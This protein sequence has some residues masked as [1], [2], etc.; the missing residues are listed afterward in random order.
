[1]G[2]RP[3]D[4]KGGKVGTW[5]GEVSTAGGG[6]MQDFSLFCGTSGDWKCTVKRLRRS[7]T[8]SGKA[9]AVMNGLLASVSCSS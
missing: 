2:K 3:A 4:A 6:T 1:M 9:S 8:G 5:P 7:S